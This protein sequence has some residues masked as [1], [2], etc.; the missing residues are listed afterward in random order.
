[1]ASST[2]SNAALSIDQE[3]AE[4]AKQPANALRSVVRRLKA[5]P[6]KEAKKSYLEA[7]RA[8]QEM[9][10]RI[11]ETKAAHDSSVSARERRDMDS[12]FRLMNVIFLDEFA[13]RLVELGNPATRPQLD[14][15]AIGASS[16]YWTGVVSAYSDEDNEEPNALKC[17]DAAF[18]SVDPAHFKRLECEKLWSTWRELGCEYRR[19]HTNFTKSGSNADFRS[20]SASRIDVYYLH[21]LTTTYKPDLL[22]CVLQKLPDSIAFDSLDASTNH[23]IGSSTKETSRYFDE[24]HR[25]RKDGGKDVIVDAIRELSA[26]RVPQSV[27]KRQSDLRE[28]EVGL[29]RQKN[30]RQKVI[31]VPALNIAQIEE[32]SKRMNLMLTL[33]HNITE[34]RRQIVQLQSKN[35]DEH[36][37]KDIDDMTACMSV[38]QRERDECM[39]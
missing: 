39:Q 20:F 11:D 17:V 18:A 4:Y 2:L 10:K 27:A 22:G 33:Q 35:V 32:K 25:K 15:K 31:H 12:S 28:E 38:M 30:E 26:S 3:M 16:S 13:D 6:E 19:V 23:E 8:A 9:G 21:L 34:L 29:K 24:K 7:I 37:Q 5:T 1:M 14:T 36:T